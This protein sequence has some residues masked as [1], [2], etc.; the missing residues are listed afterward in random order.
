[1]FLILSALASLVLDNVLFT[2]AQAIQPNFF[3]RY[4]IMGAPYAVGV[5]IIAYLKR[6]ENA[7]LRK[8]Y[9]VGTYGEEAALNINLRN[10]KYNFL[11]NIK[12]TVK[13][14]EYR[15]EVLAFATL[16]ILITLT[17]LIPS[18]DDG[19]IIYAEFP[20][21]L[22]RMLIMYFTYIVLYIVIDLATW[23]WVHR[24]WRRRMRI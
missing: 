22:L 4:I 6:R 5:A 1:M 20:A 17:M 24:Y 11:E 19:E 8:D 2:L 15:M 18:I 9:M 13:T 3:F 12:Y 21:V 7:D 23:L 16:F 10:K 14:A